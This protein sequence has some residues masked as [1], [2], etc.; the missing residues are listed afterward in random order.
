MFK[1]LNNWW[2]KKTWYLPYYKVSQY[3][4]SFVIKN[5]CLAC[6]AYVKCSE[7]DGFPD[8]PGK[9]FCPCKNNE[10]LICRFDYE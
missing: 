1:K 4:P 3:I 8:C 6:H 9:E 7:G 5:H 10:R 2:Y